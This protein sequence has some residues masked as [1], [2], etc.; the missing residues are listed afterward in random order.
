MMAGHDPR[1][2]EASSAGASIGLR[3]KPAPSYKETAGWKC[4]PDISNN[5]NIVEQVGCNM[6]L[7]HCCGF[8]V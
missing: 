4:T 2:T 7:P 1:S 3:A 5:Y 6:V 8:A